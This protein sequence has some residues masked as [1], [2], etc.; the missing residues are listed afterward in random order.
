MINPDTLSDLQILVEFSRSKN[1][2]EA[3]AKLGLSQ[4]SVSI[5]LK[6]LEHNVGFPLFEM[7]GKKKVLTPFGAEM[8]RIATEAYQRL[9]TELREAGDRF[10]NPEKLSIRIGCRKEIFERLVTS[11]R[12]PNPLVFYDMNHTQ[13]IAALLSRSV[14]L[15]ITH[16][17]PN[18]S[19]L[20]AKK[21]FSNHVVIGAHKKWG[22]DFEDPDW[23]RT[24]P[25]LLYKLKDPPY[26]EMYLARYGLSYDKLRL[27]GVCESWPALRSMTE[28]GKGFCLMPA[29]FQGKAGDC[30]FADVPTSVL[31]EQTFYM[32]YRKTSPLKKTLAQLKMQL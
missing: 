6:N 14:D 15:G 7:D 31:P 4:G 9:Q 21:L 10:A 19:D 28:D 3:A 24:T 5:R 29:E 20:I 2:I 13:V 18:S 17:V 16:Q 25:A 11:I 23:L 1:M 12:V 27:A 26:I 30:R 8:A 22:A 32:I